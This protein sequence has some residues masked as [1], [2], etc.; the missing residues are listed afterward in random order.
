MSL[1][2]AH[3]KSERKTIMDNDIRLTAIG[4]LDRLPAAPRNALTQLIELSANNRSMTLCL[5]LSYGGQ[6]ELTHGIRQIGR[7]VRDGKLD[8]ESI[9]EKVIESN[10]WSGALGPVDL[11]IRTSGELRISNFLLWSCAYAEFFFTDVMWPDFNER[12]LDEA[13]SSYERRHRRF[14]KIKT[15]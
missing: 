5:A 12:V 15:K 4:E 2:A 8:P 7:A 6:E 1:L 9:D 14:G 3:L 10:L 11:L 13:L